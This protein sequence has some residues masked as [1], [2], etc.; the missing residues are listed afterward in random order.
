MKDKRENRNRRQAYQPKLPFKTIEGIAKDVQG[1]AFRRLSPHSV[2][3][4][5]RFYERFNG[6]NRSDLEL[7]YAEV[8]HV[9][10]G[11]LFTRS[12]WQLLGFGFIDVRRFGKLEANC[13]LFA[14]SDR[15]RGLTDSPNRL[16]AIQVTLDEV[17]RLKREPGSVEKRMRIRELR[18]SLFRV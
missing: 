13:S 4:L 18:N 2:W 10:S 9:M 11:V 17:E 14:L 7:T 15:W 16:D 6:K 1:E 5:M 12:I 8:K 3:V